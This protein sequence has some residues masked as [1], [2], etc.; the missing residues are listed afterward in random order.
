VWT[1]SGWPNPTGGV[2]PSPTDGGQRS[3]S[4][5]VAVDVDVVVVVV[6]VAG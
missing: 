2:R 6:V 3:Y 4:H 1:L 5:V